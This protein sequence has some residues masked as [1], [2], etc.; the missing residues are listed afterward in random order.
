MKNIWKIWIN[1]LENSKETKDWIKRELKPRL[2]AFYRT[3]RQNLNNTSHTNYE[4]SIRARRHGWMRP[5]HIL[6]LDNIKRRSD[7]CKN[8]ATVFCKKGTIVR[9]GKNPITKNSAI[10]G[11][12][13]FPINDLIEAM[14]N[15]PFITVIEGDEYN[16]TQKCSLCFAQLVFNAQNRKKRN[17]Y[18][19]MCVPRNQILP[20][21]DEY[22]II[23]INPSQPDILTPFKTLPP[24]RPNAQVH[25]HR[26][27]NPSRNITYLLLCELNK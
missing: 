3:N 16:T 23:T 18:C 14:R 1:W 6:D 12:L 5:F 27:G 11:I 20:R 19:E 9:I 7:F 24:L 15:D 25:L 26:D 4:H 2:V 10:K 22:R 13:R 17:V 8:Y 21:P